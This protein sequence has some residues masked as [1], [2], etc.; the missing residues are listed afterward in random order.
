MSEALLYFAGS[1]LFLGGIGVLALG[2]WG[3]GN[4]IAAAHRARAHGYDADERKATY[5]AANE[6]L[7]EVEERR[8]NGRARYV[9]PSDE[10]LQEAILAGRREPDI[11]TDANE[12]IPEE[13]FMDIGQYAPSKDTL[14]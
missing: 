8:R 10:E 6:A 4:A 14:P 12:N 3:W 5:A 11:T 7:S 2:A 13:P 1:L 9:P